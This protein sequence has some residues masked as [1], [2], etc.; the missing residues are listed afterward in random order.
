MLNNND[1]AE[2]YI[3]LKKNMNGNK[4]M[5]QSQLVQILVNQGLK[6]TTAYYRILSILTKEHVMYGTKKSLQA[7]L[8]PIANRTNQVLYEFNE[9]A[10]GE[11]TEEE[12][13]TIIR[14]FAPY[15]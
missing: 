6:R 5:N 2:L 15:M 7:I 13:K 14:E 1:I 11:H 4:T 3:T 9:D 10:W 8:I 12:I